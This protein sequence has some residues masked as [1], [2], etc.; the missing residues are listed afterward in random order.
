MAQSLFSIFQGFLIIDFTLFPK[1][2]AMCPCGTTTTPLAPSH[3]HVYKPTLC[4]LTSTTSFSQNLRFQPLCQ[5]WQRLWSVAWD[6]P[7]ALWASCWALS[8]LSKACAQV[9]PLDI[10]GLCE[11]HPRKEGKNSDISELRAG[12]TAQKEGKWEEFVDTNVVERL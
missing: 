5:S 12:D 7:W 4:I 3:T 2:D 10:R 9:V 11:L 8:S 1:P 6:W